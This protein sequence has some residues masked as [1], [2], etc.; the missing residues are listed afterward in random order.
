MDSVSKVQSRLQLSTIISVRGVSNCLRSRLSWVTREPLP[1]SRTMGRMSGSRYESRAGWRLGLYA[2]RPERRVRID[3]RK[4][5]TATWNRFR[6][7]GIG[8]FDGAGGSSSWSEAELT[9]FSKPLNG[10]EFRGWNGCVSALPACLS[11]EEWEVYLSMGIGVGYLAFS[12]GR[13]CFC[14]S[15]PRMY[16]RTYVLLFDRVSSA[17]FRLDGF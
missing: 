11:V 15:L 7:Q 12:R 10:R 14:L 2:K 16:V 4:E 5:L 3:G 8:W 9:E 1:S 17:S 13:P 6:L